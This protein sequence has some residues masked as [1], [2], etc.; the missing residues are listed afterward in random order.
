[1]DV[2]K[3]A[4]Y[5]KFAASKLFYG[6]DVDFE[7]IAAIEEYRDSLPGV[8]LIVDPKRLY[9]FD[10][11]AAHLLGYTREVAE[12]E[13]KT[14]GDAYAPG[15]LTGK[16]GLEKA[17]EPNIRGQKGLQFVAVN[18]NGQRVASFN[19][20]KSDLSGLE[21]DDLYLGLDTD[22]QELAEKLMGTA[23]GSVV[24]V[25]PRNGEILC[26]VSKP[27]YDP[28]LFSGKT[29]RTYYNV[30]RDAPG[31]PLYNRAT[32]GVYPPGSTWKPLMALMAMQEGIIT[33]KTRLP[34]IGGY[35]FG[36]RF[37]TCHGGVHGMIDYKTAIAVSCNSFFYQLGVKM[38]LE[39][40]HY[41][42]AL[43]GFGQRTKLDIGEER[44]GILPSRGY[45]DKAVGKGNWTNYV[46]MN[47]G[48]GQ[49]EV[50]VTPMQMV[51]YTAAISMNGLWNQPHAVREIYSKTMRKR[52]PV[53]YES[54]Q[55]PI[56]ADHF[57]V[58]KEAMREVVSNGT[59][60]SV[61]LPGFDVCGKT[62]TADVRKGQPPQ[63]WFICFAPMNDPKIAMVV[64]GEGQGYGAAFAAPI[65]RK[66]LE[67][68][69][70]QKWPADVPRDST[71]LRQP[72]L[73]PSTSPLQDSTPPQRGPFWKAPKERPVATMPKPIAAVRSSTTPSPR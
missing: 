36:N 51:A 5:N 52:M 42:G 56:D 11:N 41:Y 3:A 47:W 25:D 24:A 62:G 34:C 43:F 71:W 63:S 54:R 73:T 7:V 29:G 13:L 31:I 46:L 19:D 60:R 15:D 35:R 65:A 45:M 50:S 18:K 1:M 67:Q 9:A 23:R 6:R 33:E 22:L 27:D 17:Y 68:F 4:A 26:F 61:D 49:G 53:S 21:G 70:L 12:N 69:F 57:R 44:A 37:A 55:I 72:G 10:G 40:F 30:V 14:L 58:I 16:T 2:A 20:G 66:L 8:D 38:G 64:T 28:R 48:I 32:Q 59:A 39:K